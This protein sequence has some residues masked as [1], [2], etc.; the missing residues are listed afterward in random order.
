MMTILQHRHSLKW[1]GGKIINPW[2]SAILATQKFRFPGRSDTENLN[3]AKILAKGKNI[4]KMDQS[5]ENKIFFGWVCKLEMADIEITIGSTKK[6]VFH[7]YMGWKSKKR[8]TVCKLWCKNSTRIPFYSLLKTEKYVEDLWT[9]K[10]CGQHTGLGWAKR[11][12]IAMCYY[13]SRYY[14]IMITK[15]VPA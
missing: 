14:I 11:R 3:N 9:C 13:Q 5:P 8:I 15:L 12:H 4:S 2:W 10:R 7:K 1:I 6:K